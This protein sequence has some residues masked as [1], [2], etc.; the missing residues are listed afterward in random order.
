MICILYIFGALQMCWGVFLFLLYYVNES[1]ESCRKKGYL[2]NRTVVWENLLI[3]FI[4]WCYNVASLGGGRYY[5][6]SDCR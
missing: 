2:G 5:A 3:C 6:G 1:K 4:K